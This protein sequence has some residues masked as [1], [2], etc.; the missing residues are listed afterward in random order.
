M[1]RLGGLEVLGTLKRDVRFA[2]I[3]VFVLTTS[4]NPAELDACYSQGASACLIKPLE[5]GAFGQLLHRLG[6]FLASVRMPPES[7]VRNSYVG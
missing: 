4:D 1:P 2:H 7:Q 6:E 5:Y 3:P